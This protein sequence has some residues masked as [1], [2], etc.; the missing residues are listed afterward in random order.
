VG[1]TATVE[2]VERVEYI[3]KVRIDADRVSIR[4]IDSNG[5]AIISMPVRAVLEEDDGVT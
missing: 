1:V 3:Q 2:Q 4:H 5:K